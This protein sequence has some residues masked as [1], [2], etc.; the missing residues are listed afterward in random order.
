MRQVQTARARGGLSLAELE[1]EE[2]VE[3]ADREELSLVNANLAAP[4]NV[5]L[6]ANVL[7]D[8]AVAYAKA[9]QMAPIGQGI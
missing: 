2:V 8:N 3:L 7:S 1:S 5:G 9:Q 6:A 4:I